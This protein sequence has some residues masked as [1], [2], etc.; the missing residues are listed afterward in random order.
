MPV[1]TVGLIGEGDFVISTLPDVLTKS[2]FVVTS[3]AATPDGPPEMPAV[4]FDL[5]IIQ[6]ELASMWGEE[7]F[8]DF[9]TSL[10]GFLIADSGPSAPRSTI[11]TSMSPEEILVAVGNVIHRAPSISGMP[12]RSSNRIAVRIPVIYEAE[13]A[14]RESAITTL[15]SNGVF[16]NTLM[17]LAAGAR[18]GLVFSLPESGTEI[19]ATGRV[20]Y[21]VGFD[22][23][24]GAIYHEGDA[25]HKPV[26]AM[27]GM[28]VLIE[29][30]GPDERRGLEEFV[31]SDSV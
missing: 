6:A 4:G 11:N 23:D 2:G 7:R 14:R 15:S 24:G 19:T 8:F 1:M 13:G 22:I 26:I 17:P 18:M 25:A 31:A 21:S 16:I 30:I 20:L 9:V 29:E 3:L 5:V 28:A 27:P 10:K 12:R